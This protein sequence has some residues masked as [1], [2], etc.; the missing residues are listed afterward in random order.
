MLL[1]ALLGVFQTKLVRLVARHSGIRQV[2][3]H[4]IVNSTLMGTQSTVD[5]D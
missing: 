2:M 3:K 5:V 1:G 4:E